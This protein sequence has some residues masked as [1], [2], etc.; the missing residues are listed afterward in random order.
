M[1]LQE[2]GM[3]MQGAQLAMQKMALQSKLAA[4][5]HE[6]I[7]P[8]SVRNFREERGAGVD[9]QFAPDRHFERVQGGLVGDAPARDLERCLAELFLQRARLGAAPVH[10][11]DAGASGRDGRQIFRDR[12]K[13]GSL[14]G[15]AAELDDD[16]G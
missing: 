4:A 8:R 13:A 7:D 12:P 3:Q 1:E 9:V 5:A 2:R 16:H 10:H 15:V 11:D 14:D 6:Q